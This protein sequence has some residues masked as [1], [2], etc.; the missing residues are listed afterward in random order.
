M[1]DVTLRLATDPPAL[2]KWHLRRALIRRRQDLPADRLYN[3]SEYPALTCAIPGPRSNVSSAPFAKA[4][5]TGA[6]WTRGR[7]QQC[8]Y[9][10]DDRCPLCGEGTD[11]VLHRI[12]QCAETKPDRDA[13]A[14]TPAPSS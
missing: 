6:L 9:L 12:W 14:A 8:G 13:T 2:I 4:L 7:M 5:A 1:G 10:V 11:T 3:S